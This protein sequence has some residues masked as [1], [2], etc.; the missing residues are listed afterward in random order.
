[1]GGEA[2]PAVGFGF[3]DAVIVELLKMKNKLPSFE[4]SSVQTMVFPMDESL[5]P[6]AVAVAAQLRAAGLQVDM[7][8]E[9]KK[10]KWVFQRADK[11]GAG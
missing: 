2:L 3:G 5:R 4:K 8:L 9:S 7:V 11:I 6:K 10:P 1:M